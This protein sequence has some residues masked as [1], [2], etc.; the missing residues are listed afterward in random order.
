MRRFAFFPCPIST[1][2]TV[3]LSHYRAVMASADSTGDDVCGLVDGLVEGLFSDMPSDLM[4]L[5]MGDPEKG[6]EDGETKE[7]A[8]AS[9]PAGWGEKGVRETPLCDRNGIPRA[10]VVELGPG[11]LYKEIAWRFE[12]G[13]CEVLKIERV[14]NGHTLENLRN[15]PRTLALG[16]HP[17]NVNQDTVAL[18]HGTPDVEKVPKILLE[19]FRINHCKRGHFGSGHYFTSD[20]A[21]AHNYAKEGKPVGATCVQFLCL[22]Y[23]GKVFRY[24]NG[25]NN[26]A[27]REPPEGHDAVTGDMTGH[28]EFIVYHNCQAYIQY[29]ITYRRIV[30]SK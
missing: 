19:G 17:I 8:L 25:V 20:P 1:H 9:Y 11:P 27:L 4:E 14:D 2:T 18:Y 30:E 24:D 6:F 21:K 23:L 22:V 29:V 3:L 15:A 10:L 16:D 7:S 13:G 12:R 28:P 5:D 26:P